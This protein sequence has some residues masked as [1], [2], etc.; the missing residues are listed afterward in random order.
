LIGVGVFFTDEAKLFETIL[1]GASFA[2]KDGTIV[3]FQGKE[4]KLKAAIQPL[5]SSKLVS[6]A[7]A[8]LSAKEAVHV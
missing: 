2:E 7:L 1:P 6:E 8:H 3:N 4:Q 5:G